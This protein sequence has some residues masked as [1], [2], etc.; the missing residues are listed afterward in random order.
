MRKIE[1]KA[2]YYEWNL[3][4]DDEFIYV[5]SDS[6]TECFNN[7][8][9]LYDYAID[10]VN[11]IDDEAKQNDYG[12]SNCYGFTGEHQQKHREL[13]LSLTKDEKEKVIEAIIKGWSYYVDVDLKARSFNYKGYHFTPIGNL[14]GN[15]VKKNHCLDF[16]DI[17][18]IDG[19]EHA[20]FYKVAKKHHASCDVFEINGT[21]YVPC[22][23]GFVSVIKNTFIKPLDNYTRWY[24]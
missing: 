9:E 21:N 11:C 5:F 13:W 6:N 4:I 18:K 3:F 20:D 8:D 7:L 23:A 16:K 19:Y 1:F 14:K 10:C 2:G 17:I 12:E 22:N 24:H 15:W